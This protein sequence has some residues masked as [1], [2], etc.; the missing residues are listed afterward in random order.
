M[1]IKSI[2]KSIIAWIKM[3][4]PRVEFFAKPKHSIKSIVDY[5]ISRTSLEING[6]IR[7][8]KKMKPANV[9]DFNLIFS[10]STLYQKKTFQKIKVFNEHQVSDFRLFSNGAKIYGKTLPELQNDVKLLY[11]MEKISKDIDNPVLY[12]KIEHIIQCLI[13][14][15]FVS[16]LQYIRIIDLIGNIFKD[17]ID[18]ACYKLLKIFDNQDYD[19]DVMVEKIFFDEYWVNMDKLGKLKPSE[20]D[21]ID[22]QLKKFY[23]MYYKP[24]KLCKKLFQRKKLATFIKQT[25][26]EI[27]L[28][29]LNQKK[30]FDW[31]I[32]NHHLLSLLFDIKKQDDAELIST[33]RLEINQINYSNVSHLLIE[34]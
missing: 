12:D 2:S 25:P 3:Q 9:S 21:F 11:D 7:I 5:W 4:Y 30:L 10:G 13:M 22:I 31:L 18:A 32:N 24:Y 28:P 1:Y 15:E 20:S 17:S 16:V 34:I 14:Y 8:T 26:D 23:Q 29:K 19:V 27:F 33:R 6:I